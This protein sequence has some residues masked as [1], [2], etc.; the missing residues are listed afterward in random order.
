MIIKVKFFN[1]YKERLLGLI[2]YKKAFPILFITRFG[3]HTFGMKF[4]IDVLVLNENYHVV[5]I[6]EN[7][8]PGNFFFWQF[9]YNKVLEL[10][11]GF[12]R[13]HKIK[14]EDKLSLKM[15]K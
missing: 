15:V 8:K 5:K 10:P 3:I 1:S 2:P 13:S 4:P 14:L 9:K 11:S 12:I 6:A 7:L